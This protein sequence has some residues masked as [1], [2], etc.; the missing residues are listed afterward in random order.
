MADRADAAQALHR[1]RHFPVRP[2]FDEDLEAAKLDDV[3]ADLM[4]PILLVEQDR[5]LAVPLDAGHRL[6]RDAAQL[7]RAIA[8]VSRLSMSAPSVV[9]QEI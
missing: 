1:D 2:P 9:V 6:D 5:H 7:V 8:A 4:D 3:Q